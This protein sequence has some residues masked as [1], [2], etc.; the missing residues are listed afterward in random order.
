LVWLGGINIE[1]PDALTKNL[2]G[3]TVDHGSGAP[4]GRYHCVLY[5]EPS[6]ESW[7]VKHHPG[8]NDKR[9]HYCTA[10]YE[11]PDQSAK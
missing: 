9:Q 7:I 4:Y 3:V 2:Y 8:H 11:R 6:P 1:Q 5:S 10:K